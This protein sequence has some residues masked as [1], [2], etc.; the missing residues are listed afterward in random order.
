MS[1]VDR[2]APAAPRTIPAVGANTGRPAAPASTSPASFGAQT[3]AA[4]ETAR[5]QEL[6]E[7]A[8]RENLAEII[9]RDPAGARLLPAVVERTVDELLR[10]QTLE[11][12]V[13]RAVRATDPA[14]DV[15]PTTYSRLKTQLTQELPEAAVRANLVDTLGADPAFAN[16][17]E[18]R[19]TALANQLL[20]LDSVSSILRRA[21]EPAR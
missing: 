20:T 10:L 9:T 7:F 17:S 16:F 11:Q 19:L 21:L 6:P 15:S 8:V 4:L 18:G 13:I 3:A 1:A 5:I 2:F 14:V 12:T